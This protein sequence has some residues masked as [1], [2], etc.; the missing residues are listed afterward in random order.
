MFKKIVKNT[1][2]LSAGIL[3]SR[4]LGLV[5]DVVIAKYFGT[6]RIFEAFI[7]AF[8]IPNIFRSLFGEG[9]SDSV[10]TPVLSEHQKNRERLVV[11]A[12]RLFS[13]FFVILLIFVILG[14]IFGKYFVIAIAPGFL[15]DSSTFELA[16]SFT[17][18]TFP[19]LFFVGL[20]AVM[21]SLLYALK[22]FTL[23]AFV[24]SL[25]NICMI[26]G[27]FFFRRRLDNYIL[28]VS[29][30]TAGVIQFACLYFYLLRKG[31]VMKM[32]LK[33]SFQD[34]DIK[35]MFKLF[36]P[37]IWAS[38]VYHLNVFV[39]TVF[40]SLSWIVG[41]GALAAIYY[42]NRII[43]FPLALIAISVSRVAIV[44]L[45]EFHKE[46][47]LEKF[48]QLFVFSLRSILFFIVPCSI[49]LL[50]M[51]QEIIEVLFLRGTFDESSCN[52][53]H[54][55]L[56]FYAFGLFPF[57]GIKLL[58]N[59]FYSL[60]DTSTPAK[61]A[62]IALVVNIILSALLMFPLKVSGIALASSLA[63]FLNFFMLYRLLIKRIGR[64]NWQGIPQEIVKLLFLG[65]VMGGILKL[66]W[67]YLNY[68]KYI[69]ITAGT[70]SAAAVFLFLA[71]VL[72]I[73]YFQYIKSWI[74]RKK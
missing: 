19:Y 36:I 54:P 9:F 40:S 34:K 24:P 28:V 3:F 53:T 61:T 18:V 55:V 32:R 52:I 43:Q 15:K 14:M 72:K 60:K 22:K 47:D 1:G 39:D 16:V 59:S 64:L 57:C 48:K 68:N 29:V 31:I 65:L 73:K 56:F 2:V 71:S 33:Q 13:V 45:S 50:L 25:F 10:A 62:A 12:S 8:R 27:V 42:S 26:V 35:R 51:S 67:I 20:V 63:A 30:L 69:R 17:R 46:N 6:S 21:S 74:L 41:G 49:I 38:L 58:V 5:R 66:F 37:R 11:L 23:P 70:I 7:V 4:I 44:D